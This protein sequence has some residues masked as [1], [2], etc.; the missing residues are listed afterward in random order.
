MS[1]F[2]LDD[3][4]GTAYILGQSKIT[5][6]DFAK[7]FARI[8]QMIPSEHRDFG[9]SLLADVIP[10]AGLL[11]AGLPGTVYSKEGWKPEPQGLPGAPYV[12]N[13]AAQFSVGGTTYGLAVT[14]G[15]TTN[16]MSGEA[17]IQNL[18]AALIRP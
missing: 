13:Q 18:V 17:I 8:D 9:L 2:V 1:N 14:V 16:Q 3:T 15:G 5:A 4:T 6:N 7:F 10:K 12:V 11:R